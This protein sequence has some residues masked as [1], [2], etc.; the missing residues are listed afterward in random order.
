MSSE[1]SCVSGVT[2]PES[3]CIFFSRVLILQ[4][5]FYYGD[6]LFVGISKFKC[7][8]VIVSPGCKLHPN[9]YCVWAASVD[10]WCVHV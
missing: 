9:K 7:K 4:Y 2:P 8:S 6:N 1:M 10:E 3:P 5:G